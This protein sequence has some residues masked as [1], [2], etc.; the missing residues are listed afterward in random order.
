MSKG[1]FFVDGRRIGADKIKP[2][3]LASAKRVE[4]RD[5]DITALPALDAATDVWVVNC[6]GLT[7]LP[8]LDAATVVRVDNCPGLT[9]L[10]ALDA[11]TDVRVV[12]CPGLTKKEV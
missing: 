11:A 8:A 6:P 12:N 7:A 2:S 10:P 9:A 5:V 4:I 3:D 1:Y